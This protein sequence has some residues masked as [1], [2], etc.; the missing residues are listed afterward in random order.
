MA[1]HE[2][3]YVRGIPEPLRDDAARLYDEA[4]GGKLAL[5]I[6]AR[7]AR[8]E[9]IAR[10]F[11]PEYGIAAIEGDALVGLVGFHTAEGSLTGGMDFRG[12]V[13]MLGPMRG[14]RAALVFSFYERAPKPGQLLLDGIAVRASARGR[15]VGTRLLAALYDIALSE[16]YNELRLDVIDTNPA[17][18]RLYERNGFIATETARFNYLRWLLGFGASTTMV[19]RVSRP[20]V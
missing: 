18:R 20:T 6:P 9:L 3:E 2:I 10:S 11:L 19:R 13:A 17:A 4:F 14:M 7:D 12:C 15:G 5:A 1:V 16:G 8:I